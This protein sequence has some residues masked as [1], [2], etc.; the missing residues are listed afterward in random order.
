MFPDVIS[1]KKIPSDGASWPGILAGMRLAFFNNDFGDYFKYLAGCFMGED[2]IAAR[3]GFYV[4]LAAMLSRHVRLTP[5]LYEA[6]PA[7]DYIAEDMTDTGDEDLRRAAGR[8]AAACVS[9][10]EKLDSKGPAA[11]GPAIVQAAPAPEDL[12]SFI[13]DNSGDRKKLFHV[14]IDGNMTLG[15]GFDR[16]LALVGEL[17]CL[18]AGRADEIAAAW[19]NGSAGAEDFMRSF[20]EDLCH[21]LRAAEENRWLIALC[22]LASG[23]GLE[24]PSL[25]PLQAE[26]SFKLREYQNALDSITAAE[27][28]HA[29]TPYME[30]LKCVSLWLTSRPGECA[31]ILRRRLSENSGDILA[32][33]LAGDVFLDR[34]MFENAVKAY[35]YAYHLDPASPDVLYALARA[36]HACYFAGQADLCVAA[37]AKASPAAAE[38]FRFGVELYVKCPQPGVRAVVDGIDAGECPQC[39]RGVECGRKVIEWIS[40]GRVIKRIEA[41]LKDGYVQKFKYFPDSGTV[42]VDES[43]EGRITLY[44]SGGVFELDD[45]LKDYAV[46]SLADL[47]KPS[48]DDFLGADTVKTL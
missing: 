37:A 40:G 12:E 1:E 14:V 29:L 28:A 41:D 15:A 17:L 8:L 2:E 45:L 35:V 34:N 42:D 31:A 4:P 7:I 20:A 46:K 36:Y 19:V 16:S 22:R 6:Y 10:R 18:D 38:K 13:S 23:C 43:R 39:L 33:L 25:R 5:Q 27:A 21:Q 24:F 48:V 47:P 44:R 32:A 11:T 3:K 26:A 9:A 30:H